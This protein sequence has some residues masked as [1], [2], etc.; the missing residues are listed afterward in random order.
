MN[1]YEQHKEKK[2]AQIEA[3]LIRNESVNR[4]EVYPH[5]K[6]LRR[7]LQNDSEALERLEFMVESVEN[8]I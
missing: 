5:R 7:A 6:E 1:Y 2:I 4:F 3:A 8:T